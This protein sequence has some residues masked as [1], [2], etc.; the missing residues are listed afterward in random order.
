MDWTEIQIHLPAAQL[1]R[2][3]ELAHMA[4]PY[5]FYTEDYSRLREEVEEIAHIDLIDE[6]L[7]EKDPS[8]AVIHIYVSHADSPAEVT[9]YLQEALKA[10][11]VDFFIDTL[12]IREEDWANNWK[13]Y[14]KPLEI[15]EKLSVVPSW[16]SYDNKD[17]RL[18][19]E[20]D[21]SS[22]FGT[23]THETTRLCLE[24]LQDVVQEGME[25]LDIGCG[26]GIL[27]VAAC[28]LGA[29]KADGVDI[30]PMAVKVAIDN[31]IMNDMTE[32]RYCMR[33]G[34]LVH[35]ITGR[36][37]VII[38]NIV[39]DVIISLLGKVRPFLKESGV[40]VLSGII[41]L[42][43]QEVLD[44]LTK[45]GFALKERYE[46]KNWVCLIAL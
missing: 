39:A 16:E 18:I 15:G 11:G 40:L 4:V 37:D 6:A 20:L 34:D 35:T 22:A 45:N 32:P 25:T 44:A 24:V 9:A 5:G 31:G 14:F 21:P 3:E 19:L 33:Q 13:Q 8:K 36:Y 28:L 23:G 10:S 38:A 12:T 30:D 2:A 43:E 42:R 26:S 7:L 29:A 27:S 1:E 46:D 17:N 41:D